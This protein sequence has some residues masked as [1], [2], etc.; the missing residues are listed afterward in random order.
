LKN[1]VKTYKIA[2]SV[3]IQLLAYGSVG[4]GGRGGDDFK[5]GGFV[6]KH[7]E[8]TIAVLSKMEM[9]DMYEFGRHRDLV[10]ALLTIYQ[11][12]LIDWN[13]LERKINNNPMLMSK[14][15]SPKNYILKIEQ[16]YNHNNKER[17]IIA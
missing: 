13:V 5:N 15:L 7:Y 4:S 16:V 11:K 8:L 17:K 1:V 10:S 14:C 6:I 3:A 2:I 9:F 12:G